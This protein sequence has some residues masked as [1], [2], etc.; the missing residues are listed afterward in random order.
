MA[1]T[2]A[3]SQG[4]SCMSCHLRYHTMVMVGLSL[5][6]LRH[7]KRAE[8]LLKKAMLYGK[9]LIKAKLV[10]SSDVYTEGM[11]EIG[12]KLLLIDCLR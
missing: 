8:I 2:V 9:S 11:S 6:K 5:K 7:Y 10:K 12:M 3:E 4:E 1:L